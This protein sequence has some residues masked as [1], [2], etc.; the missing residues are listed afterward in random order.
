MHDPR[1][2]ELAKQLVGY[3]VAL[4]KGEKVLIDL[5]DVPDSIGLALIRQ[6]RKKGGIPLLRVNHSRLSR[7]ML[8][9]AT[10]DQYKIISKHLM[11]EMK[12]VDAYIAV[13]GSDNIAENSDVPA[14]QMGLATACP[15]FYN[16]PSRST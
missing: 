3:S 12:D 1:V 5:F 7:E 11:G 13:R 14:K 9:G 4:K 15:F 6:A 10:E 16:P 8:T 2:D